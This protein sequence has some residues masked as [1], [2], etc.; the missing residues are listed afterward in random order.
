MTDIRYR[1]SRVLVAAS[2][3]A[4]VTPGVALAEEEE[5]TGLMLL[6]PNMSEFVPACVAFIIIL[7]I[8]SKMAWPAVLKT[9]DE[10]EKKIQG[11]LDAA[12]Q[13]REKAE[14]A[15]ADIAARLESAEREAQEIIAEAKRDAENERS[16]IIAE[17]QASAQALIAKA[18][19]SVADEREK[20]MIELSGQ[21]VD[22]SVEIASKI[23]GN[24]LSEDAQRE[25]AERYLLE[26]GSLY[27]E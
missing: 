15:E 19:A 22:L 10:R 23:I 7:I 14:A 9:M 24:G 1:A 3:L 11:D 2:L 5:N 18:H 4:S 13:A 16:R 17:G 12:A 20:A 6:M 27:E 25:L 21:V 26:V 8:V